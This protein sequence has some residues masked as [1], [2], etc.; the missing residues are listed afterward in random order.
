MFRSVAASAAL[1]LAVAASPALAQPFQWTGV[2]MGVQ[3]GHLWGTGDVAYPDEYLLTGPDAD[4]WPGFN[5]QGNFLGAHLGMNHQLSPGVVVGVETDFNKPLG[6]LVDAVDAYRPAN[7]ID[8]GDYVGNL[9]I[10]W[11]GSTRL[12]FGSPI[13]NVMPFV[14][15]GVGYA[16][17]HFFVTDQD[18]IYQRAEP[19][20]MFGVTGG[21]GTA[22]AVGPHVVLTGEYR[23]AVY[24]WN[25]MGPLMDAIGNDPPTPYTVA[26]RATTHALIFGLSIKY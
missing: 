10:D 14:S 26:A 15:I 6:D 24:R 16:G 22:V 3:G 23:F 5:F 9:Q 18:G 2:Y 1:L 11:F 4:G 13:G 19:S 21:V 12:R 7:P 25:D 20:V 8:P 17:Y